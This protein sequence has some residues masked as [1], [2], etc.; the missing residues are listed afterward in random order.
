[1][2]TSP[3]V[4]GLDTLHQ[5]R[6]QLILALQDIAGLTA[7]LDLLP[8]GTM[9]KMETLAR[10]VQRT[11]LRVAFVG[12]FSR[13]KTELINA[14]FFADGAPTAQPDLSRKGS[15]LLPSSSGQT[16]MCPVE[17]QGCTRQGP[18]PARDGRHWAN[19]IQLLPIASRTLDVPIERLKNAK[20]AWQRFSLPLDD[21]PKR[22]EALA[23]LTETICVDIEEARKMGL[24]PPLN[25]T[26]KG[27]ERTVCPTCGLGKVRIPRW[28]HA[29][30]H[31][32]HPILNAGLTVFD[33][34][35]LNAI[36]AEPELTFGMLAEA[37]AILFL[38]GADTGVTQSDLSIWDQY[39]ARNS[40]QQQ[41][42][43]LN[44]IDTLWDELQEAAAIE[45]EIAQ[46]VEKTAQQLRI[47]AH[48][49]VPVSG[50]QGLVAKVRKDEKL[51]KRS[52]LPALEQTMA[53]IL[54][55]AQHA[56]IRKTCEAMVKNRL[57]EQKSRL[58]EERQRLEAQK[59]SVLSLKDRTEEK[60]PKLIAQHQ[61]LLQR[62]H[63]DRLHFEAQSQRF[64][65]AVEEHL[66][67]PLSP[68]DFDVIINQARAEMLSAWT[69]GGIVERLRRF[70]SE[71][72]A[73][74]D[75]ALSGAQAVSEGFAAEYQ[76]LQAQ[77]ALPDLKTVPYAMMPRRAE[78]LA[79]AE[80]YERFGKTMEIAV[81]TQGA[82]VRKMFL[83]V[84][85]RTRDFVMETRRDAE[86]WVDRIMAVM[87]QQ[88]QR[89]EAQTEEELQAL[90]Q[91]AKAVEF[92]ETRVQQLEQALMEVQSK[93][94]RL[95]QA[96]L[97]F[98]KLMAA[99]ILPSPA[100]T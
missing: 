62:F 4:S 34:P 81:N 88:L 32:D 21:A 57:S 3:I 55:P 26:P 20:S 48:Q 73:H 33:T 36:G 12:E 17:I 11:A 44:K 41:I 2:N 86:S 90:Q 54:V 56:A 92:V 89:F 84:A 76:A 37:D 72:I 6:Q 39:L 53:D 18:H 50:H 80:T 67:T 91:I 15:R 74:F 52:G 61:A 47:A 95:N 98:M 38:L 69:T 8:S 7:D 58:Q 1:M 99:D 75:R 64:H 94:E 93:E 30:I 25:R 42:V 45:T 77:Y 24:C 79:M 14:L 23:R 5:W 19:S 65:Q 51:L 87:D 78:L 40:Q 100:S 13:G 35:G 28:R 63:A 10:D 66:L 59:Q 83:T 85:M 22:G 29:I 68:H 82:V 46:Q 70:F 31:M 97:P 16:T 60:V 27:M 49:V 9:L 96:V 43:L 71:A